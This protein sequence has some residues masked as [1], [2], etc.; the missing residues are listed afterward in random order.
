VLPGWSAHA[1][2]E[3]ARA[4]VL[5]SPGEAFAAPGQLRC[6][7]LGVPVDQA[8]QAGS[9]VAALLAQLGRPVSPDPAPAAAGAPA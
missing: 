6:C 3:L 5:A 4:G 2:A 7:L 8:E 9:A 1:V